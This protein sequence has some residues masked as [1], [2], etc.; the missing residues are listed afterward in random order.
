MNPLAFFTLG[1]EEK[2][3]AFTPTDRLSV[4]VGDW[5]CGAVFDRCRRGD[6]SF[7]VPTTGD[8]VGFVADSEQHAGDRGVSVSLRATALGASFFAFG[9]M[10]R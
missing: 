8:G 6:V 4:V 10:G 5:C 9:T 7:G 1:D 3:T 2:L